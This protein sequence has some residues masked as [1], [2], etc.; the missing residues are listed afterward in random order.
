MFVV[1][2]YNMDIVVG[3]LYSLGIFVGG[4]YFEY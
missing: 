2:K 1:V 3:G 4:V